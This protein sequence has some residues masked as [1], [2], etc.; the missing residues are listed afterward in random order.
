MS[1]VE[2]VNGTVTDPFQARF[3][4]PAGTQSPE[5]E[6]QQ[7]E[8]LCRELLQEREKL[9][10]DVAESNAKI[11]RYMIYLEAFCPFPYTKE[12][13]EKMLAE[14]NQQPPIRQVFDELM[15]KYVYVS[16]EPHTELLQERDQLHSELARTKCERDDFLR[17]YSDKVAEGFTLT[18]EEVLARLDQEP[19]IFQVIAD[20]GR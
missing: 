16:A 6:R 5:A 15:E 12:E 4:V 9:R 3:G 19:T 11:G 10:A 14:V 2:Q 13:E 20:L 18:K 1:G 8:Q 17:M 7:W